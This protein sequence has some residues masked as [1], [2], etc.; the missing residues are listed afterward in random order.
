MG[1]FGLY[2]WP[3][4]DGEALR[5]KLNSL[6]TPVYER[7][8]GGRIGQHVGPNPP[9]PLPSL[10]LLLNRFVESDGVLRYRRDV[11]TPSG[12]VLA[13]AGDIAGGLGARGYWSIKINGVRYKRSRLVFKLRTGSDPLSDL[14]H[15]NLDTA[16]DRFENLRDVTD[17]QNSRNCWGRDGSSYVI[18]TEHVSDGYWRETIQFSLGFRD[19]EPANDVIAELNA[20]ITP[21]VNAFLAAR[22]GRTRP[23]SRLAAWLTPEPQPPLPR[24][25]LQ[26]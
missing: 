26:E 4:E 6:V 13:A 20:L 10:E 5:G 14:D 8:L 12:R 18:C 15:I 22:I 2:L 23:P 24:R 9:N 1:R 17:S 3:G 19:G 21:E 25:Q 11:T 16:D 7:V